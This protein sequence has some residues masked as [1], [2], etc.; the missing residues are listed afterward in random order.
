MARAND[1]GDQYPSDADDTAPVDPILGRQ[2]ED[3]DILVDG[4]NTGGIGTGQAHQRGNLSRRSID[5]LRP[6]EIDLRATRIFDSTHYDQT[7]DF[8]S[9]RHSTFA[10]IFETIDNALMLNIANAF[11]FDPRRS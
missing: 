1:I 7:D 4:V 8:Q 2:Q 11:V 9:K 6:I 10:S 3:Y 5:N